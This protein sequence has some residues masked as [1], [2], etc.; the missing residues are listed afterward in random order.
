MI[1]DSKCITAVA[2]LTL[3]PVQAQ[4][5]AV[6]LLNGIVHGDGLLVVDV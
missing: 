2:G 5:N 3:P 4:L 6:A 1:G